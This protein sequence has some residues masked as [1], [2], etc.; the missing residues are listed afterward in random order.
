[1]PFPETGKPVSEFPG[2]FSGF[3]NLA[4]KGRVFFIA[5]ST[6]TARAK[7]GLLAPLHLSAKLCLWHNAAGHR[8]SS[9][10]TLLSAII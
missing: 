3:R 7:R 2:Q 5:L 9:F 6:T 10:K 1:V 8:A 4:H